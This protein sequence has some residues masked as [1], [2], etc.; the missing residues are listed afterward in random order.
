MRKEFRL[1]AQLDEFEIKNV[2][3]DIEYDVNILPKKTW[4]ALGKP[5]L[6]YSPI[7]LRIANQ[8]CIFLIRRLANV[9]IDVVE[10]K[11]ITY[12]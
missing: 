8:Y 10:V 4:E 12:F 11:T 1:V 6:I 2:M 7:Q 9:E 5:Q 3:L